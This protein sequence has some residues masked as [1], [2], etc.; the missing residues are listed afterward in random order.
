MQGAHLISTTRSIS[1]SREE[2]LASN[3]ASGFS[4]QASSNRFQVLGFVARVSGMQIWVSGFE[5]RV[6]SFKYQDSSFGC[7]W[8]GFRASIRVSSLGV[9][10]PHVHDA[11]HLALPGFEP[12]LG[13]KPV[14]DL[15]EPGERRDE[16]SQFSHITVNLITELV[17]ANSKLII[18]RGSRLSKS[19]S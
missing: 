12:R 11:E 16:K 2:N 14:D 8:L 5:F 10:A 7:S 4:F 19:D 6:S 3:Q 1:L 17:I 13:H 18:L 9:C 15:H